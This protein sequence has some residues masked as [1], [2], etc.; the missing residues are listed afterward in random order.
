MPAAEACS[1]FFLWASRPSGR[2]HVDRGKHQHRSHAQVATTI[3]DLFRVGWLGFHIQHR[4]LPA[5][6]F[7]VPRP[8]SDILET[9]ARDSFQ[10]ALQRKLGIRQR[11][12]S[13]LKVC[14]LAAPCDLRGHRIGFPKR[15]QRRLAAGRVTKKSLL[16]KRSI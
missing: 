14:W 15:S 4:H 5:R 12:A 11:H 9:T 8:E 13:N 3:S 2:F 16:F 6:R 10:G 1:I 7:Q